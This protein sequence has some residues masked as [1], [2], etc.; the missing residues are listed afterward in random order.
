MKKPLLSFLRNPRFRYGSVST[1]IMCLCLAA[2]IALNGLFTA[3][4]KRYGWRVDYSFNAITTHSESTAQMLERLEKP[5]HIYALYER[6]SEDL[7]LFELLDRYRAASPLVT[8]EQA[9]ISLNPTFLAR[10]SGVKADHTISGDCLVVWCE[11]TE[12]FRVLDADDFLTL[13][14]DYEAGVYAYDKLTYESAITSAIAYVTQE[15]IPVVHIVQGH[16]EVNAENSAAL[17]TLLLDNH[18][19][20]HYAAISQMD[21]APADLLVFLAPV[22]DLTESEMTKVTEH[23]ANGGAMLFVCDA[24][25]PIE[26]MPN[27]QAL[28]RSYGFLPLE[29]LVV[30]DRSDKSAY[31]EGKPTVLLPEMQPSEITLDLMLNGLDTLI[32]SSARAFEV[33]EQTDAGLSVTPMLMTTENAHLRDLLSTATSLDRQ[34]GDAAGPFALAL[35]SYRFS[36]S[37]DVSRAVM[38]GSTAAVTSE[39]YYSMSHA[40]E[41]I[42]R[43]MEYLVNS[44]A[45]NLDIMARSAVRPALSANSLTLGCVLLVALPVSILAAA[46]LILTPRRHL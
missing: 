22:R 18:Y 24:S 38:I 7:T 44:A 33:P 39:Y 46:L 43:T 35:E 15:T 4:E 23:A 26:K 34:E 28:L 19:D 11:E 10:F 29:G 40:Q 12:R 41:F 3:L 21:L 6:G 13:S 27:Y 17:E 16:D 8:W 5:V 9:P 14:I 25:D 31:F 42:I 32:M 45:S 2:L 30:E 37:G 36:S 1:A 20:V